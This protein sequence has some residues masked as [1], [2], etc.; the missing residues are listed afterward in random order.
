MEEHNHE[1]QKGTL[2]HMQSYRKSP[3]RGE[4]YPRQRKERHESISWECDSR[5]GCHVRADNSPTEGH[6]TITA[7]RSNGQRIPFSSDD[8]ELDSTL[9]NEGDS[10][11]DADFEEEELGSYEQLKE[12]YRNCHS[13]SGGNRYSYLVNCSPY[14]RQN[15]HPIPTHHIATSSRSRYFSSLQIAAA[16]SDGLGDMFHR[17][18]G[19]VT[20]TLM[21]LLIVAIMLVEMVDLLCCRRRRRSFDDDD[22][23]DDDDEEEERVRKPTRRRFRTRGFRIPLVTVYEPAT[24]ENEKVA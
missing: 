19:T 11:E 15:E 3:L 12:L 18:P 22:D 13:S 7:T 17:A 23:D 9:E 14:N 1:S 5:T 21:A 24:H 6:P 8:N 2:R 10:Q 20:L 16:R 4:Y